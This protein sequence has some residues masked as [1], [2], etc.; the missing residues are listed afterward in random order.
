MALECR[1]ATLSS[2]WRHG[3]LARPLRLRPIAIL[4]A[5]ASIARIVLVVQGG[6]LYWPDERLYSQVLDIYD[7]HR[8]HSFDIVKALFATQ[9][10]LGFALITAVPAAV[11]FSI[12]H[13]L[14]RSDNGLM[15]LP[16]VVLAQASVLVIGLVYAIA[17][18]TGRDT[19]EA[20]LAALLMAAST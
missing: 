9:D 2:T 16:G 14:S 4:L 11:Q 8:G 5:L 6:Q 1:Y 3:S 18:R 15:M 20:F 13:A 12:G 7:L 10:H 19:T 17:R